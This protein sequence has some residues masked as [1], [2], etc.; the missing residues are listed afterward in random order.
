MTRF[1]SPRFPFFRFFFKLLILVSKALI[2]RMGFKYPPTVISADIGCHSC[3][4]LTAPALKKRCIFRNGWNA[5]NLSVFLER[6]G[7]GHSPSESYN[8]NQLYLC[9]G[10]MVSE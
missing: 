2:C 5:V 9:K 7:E 4:R 1:L 10:Q 3:E 6:A 8:K